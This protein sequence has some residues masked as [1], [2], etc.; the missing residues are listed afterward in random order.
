[1]PENGKQ[2]IPEEKGRMRDDVSFV[3]IE[4]YKRG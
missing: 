3:D 1:L 2:L 4:I